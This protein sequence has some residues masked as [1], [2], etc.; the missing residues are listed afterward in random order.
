MRLLKTVFHI[1][2]DY[3]DD[4]D[5]TVEH[6][7][8]AAERFGVRVLAVTD[9][10]TIDGARAMAAIA[11]PHMKVIIGEEVSTTDGH[12]IGL[13]LRET[14]EPG[15]PARKTAEQIR[16]QGGLVVVPHP[17]N[18]I[19]GCSLR[20]A[21]HDILDLVDIVEVCN[22]QN[23][24]PFPNRRADELARRHHL[25]A[26]VG[27]DTHHRDSLCPCYQLLP[28]FHSPASFLDAVER[29]ALVPGRH[30]PGYFV[31]SALIVIRERLGLPSPAGYGTNCRL[32]RR[33]MLQ[34]ATVPVRR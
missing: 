12:L 24:L 15:L 28:P 6:L 11:P 26:L 19:F 9:H 31:R 33:R 7:L 30:P 29:A 8:D 14:I 20:E 1:H 18:T 16:R 25:P 2:T 3:S 34:P 17:F 13:F 27:A 10:D 5:N 32:S 21:A 22:A 23:L 4:S